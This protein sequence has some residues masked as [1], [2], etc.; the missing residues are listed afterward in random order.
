V[1]AESALT[2][3]GVAFRDSVP[4]AF[5]S[6]PDHEVRD[7]FVPQRAT[8]LL[9][10]YERLLA[11]TVNP[12]GVTLA[13]RRARVLAAMSRMAGDPSGSKWEDD[14]IKLLGPIGTG[15]GEWYYREHDPDDP[16]SPPPNYLLVAF[17]YDPTTVGLVRAYVLSITP[18]HLRLLF[19]FRTG[20]LVGVSR[21]GDAL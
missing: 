5:R 9:G 20:F 2:P 16:T 3:L 10:L 15:V 7:Q 13:E 19:R 1:P 6:D 4:T 17:P 12:A 18:A 11:L 8:L 21:V 14:M